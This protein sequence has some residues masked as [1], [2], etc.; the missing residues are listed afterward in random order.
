MDGF[1]KGETSLKSIELDLLGDVSGKSILHLQCHFGQDSLSLAR[2]GAT[3]TGVDLSDTAIKTAQDLSAKINT[4]ADF[5]CSDVFDLT[6]H[7]DKQFDIVFTSYG[8]IAWLPDLEKWA[9]IVSHF[10]KP[11]GTFV[12]VEFHPVIWMFDDDFKD[13]IYRYF[14]S[15]PIVEIET[16]TYAQ[17]NAALESKVITWNHSIASV[18]SNLIDHN[19]EIRRLQEFDYSP[20]DCLNHLEAIE[21][22]KYRIKHLGD[23]IPM[24][25]ALLGTKKLS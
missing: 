2:M 6:N 8:T 10:L 18:V 23:K 12:F 14:K 13:I 16:G 15:E 24:T 1:L 4:K 25:Y 7:L 5:I 3:V 22:G 21:P 17:K 11:G 9:K 19:I 20:Y